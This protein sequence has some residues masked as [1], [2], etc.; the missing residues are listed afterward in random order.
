MSHQSSCALGRWTREDCWALSTWPWVD[1]RLCEAADPT[2][3]E[4]VDKGHPHH[5]APIP[6]APGQ[7]SLLGPGDMG[8]EQRENGS[9]AVKSP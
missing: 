2:Q 3:Q 6:E 8:R 9:H 4:Q 7:H 5:P 1:I